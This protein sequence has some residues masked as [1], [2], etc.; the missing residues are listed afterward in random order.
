M[1]AVHRLPCLQHLPVGALTQAVRPDIGLESRFLPTHLHSTPPLG[2]LPSE[3]CNA[4]WH[5][6]TRMVWLP[7]GWKNFVDMFIRFDRI[8]KCDRHTHR[9]TDTAWRHRP[10]LH[11]IARQKYTL[12]C[13]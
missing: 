6:K 10:C 12:W 2:G 7:D 3:Y 9:Q 1:V 5:R 4:V 8:H 11:S 13:I